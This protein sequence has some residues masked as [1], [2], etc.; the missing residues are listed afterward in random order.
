MATF[1]DLWA[2]RWGLPARRALAGSE[3]TGAFNPTFA[4]VTALLAVWARF[5]PA[6]PLLGRAD[7]A[8]VTDRARY[9]GTAITQ[10]TTR[11][12]DSRSAFQSMAALL[13]AE[14]R[15]QQ[16]CPKQ[17]RS[18]GQRM[19]LAP[20][21]GSAL[22]PTVIPW[23]PP[24]SLETFSTAFETLQVILYAGSP[25]RFVVSRH[26]TSRWQHLR[27]SS[28]LTST[29]DLASSSSLMSVTSTTQ[30]E[31]LDLSEPS[32]LGRRYLIRFAS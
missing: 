3:T 21:A 27:P 9:A 17:R 6:Q 31:P 8:P 1:A 19:D 22:T 13:A 4:G 23:E 25:I 16:H 5:E 18:P 26:F 15:Y 14:D 20:N 12:R 11:G 29:P 24:K 30:Q 28:P 10:K 2:G 7:P 32:Q